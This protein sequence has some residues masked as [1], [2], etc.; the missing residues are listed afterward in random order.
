MVD[1]HLSILGAPRSGA[2]ADTEFTTLL[3]EAL[4]ASLHEDR[5]EVH[6][7]DP[8]WCSVHPVPGSDDQKPPGQGWKL[9]VSATPVSAPEVL[10]RALPVLLAEGSA[11]KFARDRAQVAQLNARHTPR[12]HSGKFLTVYPQDD[13][14]AVRLA[15]R[16]DEVTDGL[17]GPRVLSDRPYRAGSLVHYRYGA[18]V[19]ERRISNDGMVSWVIFDPDGNPVEDRRI[20]QYLPPDWVRCPFPDNGMGSAAADG[21]GL[22]VGKR[23]LVQ[24]A[25]RQTNRGGVYQ[26]VDTRTGEAT[27]L[28]EARPHV[29]VDETGGD[30]R[31]LLRAEFRA[32]EVLAPHG[33][34]PA[35]LALFDQGGHLFLAEQLVPGTSLREWV[36]DRIRAGGWQR[37]I[38]EALDTAAHVVA[39][40]DAAHQAGL[41]LRD[42]TPNNIMVRPDGQLRLI[43]L[44]LAVPV[45]D[46]I[47]AVLG[48][49]V[50]QA[51][52]DLGNGDRQRGVAADGEPFGEPVL[53]RAGRGVLVE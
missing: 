32:L 44:E 24:Q 17:A 18:F 14:A 6:D 11:F 10:R 25:V 28:K 49:G 7:A 52:D 8:L 36:L 40:L 43:D 22:L 15:A 26:A 42:L 53:H 38:P 48:V 50:E 45:G 27:I 21:G 29:A 39:L 4:P 13:E 16:L 30:T 37:S 20:G 19:E 23:F 35:P 2:T 3:T 5:W 51:A 9:H 46:Q 12:G 33:I 1:F 41:I 47:G 34:A 31:D